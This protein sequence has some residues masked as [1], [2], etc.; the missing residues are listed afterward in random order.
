[1]KKTIN[2]IILLF[3]LLLTGWILIYNNDFSKFPTLIDKINK[4][5]Y[6][7][8]FFCM[9]FYWICDAYIIQEMKKMLNI[10]GRFSS[11]FKLALIGQYYGAITPFATGGQPAQIYLLANAGVQVGTASSLMLTKFIIYQV[12]VTFYSIFM[13]LIKFRFII[14]EA[15]LALPFIIVGC[16]LNILALLLIIGLF[17][18][19]RL[20]RII[21]TKLFT[22]GYKLRLI[23]NIAKLEDRLNKYIFDFTVSINRMKEDKKT[24]LKL[25]LATFMQLTF[26]FSIPFFVYLSIGLTGAS[27]LDIIG[28]QSLLY[29]AVSFMP[30]PG[31]IG[32]SEGGFYILYSG[33]F[34]NNI[35][36]FTML[37]WRFVDYYFGIIVGGLFTLVDFILRKNK[38]IIK[39]RA[40]TKK[41]LITI[42]NSK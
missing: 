39:T 18:N 38:N 27:Y 4:Y 36:T 2:Y 3:S 34:P 26:Y 31:T 8:A 42:V 41:Q 32:A 28:I 17:F 22:F 5:F 37:L 23:K 30:T 11:S 20:F 14:G 12:V 40:R 29:M 15:K 25:I 6:V 7:V 1:M 33:I 21:F 35:L 13:F 10:Q 24:T 9:I 19:E 16:L